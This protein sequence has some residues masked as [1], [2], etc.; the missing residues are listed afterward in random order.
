[1]RLFRILLLPLFIIVFASL[2]LLSRAPPIA[3]DTSAEKSVFSADRALQH[4]T[5]IAKAPHPT[6][7]DAIKELKHYLLNELEGLGLRTEIQ[8]T[9]V[10]N[11]TAYG[12]RIASIENIIAVKRGL[13]PDAKK[14]ALMAHYDSREN[15]FGASDDGSGIITILETLRA[16]NYLPELEND[17]VVLFTDGEETGLFGA[18]AFTQHPL[19]KQIGLILNFEAR[20]SS[21]PVVMFETSDNNA[22]LISEFVKAAPYPQ[23]DSLAYAIYKKMPNSTDL[24]ETKNAGIPGLNFAFSGSFFDYHSM[25]DRAENISADSVQHAGSYALALTQHFGHLSLPISEENKAYED[26]VYF[27]ITAHQLISYPLS[28][29]YLFAVFPLVL[30]LW[31]IKQF[32]RTESIS[33]WRLSWTA[34]SLLA[35]MAWVFVLVQ[36]L[37]SL[38]DGGIG[39]KHPSYFVLLYTQDRLFTGFSLLA[40][41]AFSAGVYLLNQ[42]PSN[43]LVASLQLLTIILMAISDNLQ[44]TIIGIFLASSLIILVQVKQARSSL[45]LHQAGFLLWGFMLIACLVLLPEAAHL[46]TWPLLLALT[47]NLVLPSY[48]PHIQTQTKILIASMLGATLAIYW[49]VSLI[50]MIYAA[51][52]LSVPGI[53]V[54]ALGLLLFLVIP[55]LIKHIQYSNGLV[56][57]GVFVAGLI[58]ILSTPLSFEFDQRYKRPDSLLYLQD[59]SQKVSESYWVSTDIEVPKWSEALFESVESSHRYAEDIRYYIPLASNGWWQAS[60]DNII[61]EPPT[62]TILLDENPNLNS[63]DKTHRKVKFKLNSLQANE[64]ISLYFSSKERIISATLN[65]KEIE[66]SPSHIAEKSWWHWRYYG[67]PKNGVDISLTIEGKEELELKVLAVDWGFS[68]ELLDSMPAR[69]EDTMPRFYSYSDAIVLFNQFKL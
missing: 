57:V 40:I 39:L 67:L 27:N 59:S 21:G 9:E 19:A 26:A 47:V 28:W 46:F 32:S 25:G 43:K 10:I 65:G 34:L 7:S 3:M 62:I 36:C 20:G 63:E 52:G 16:L 11:N 66:R 42:K 37:Y 35:L 1:M 64:N 14:L 8:Q 13:N 12:P 50:E 2:S 69:P 58:I 44:F 18:K 51:V 5:H 60:T 31:Q 53:P 29:A 6:G 54:S 24:T 55:A 30:L 48:F 68:K 56:V 22:A 4:L 23:A 49:M 17:L 41:A 38:I 33:L 15:S 61:T 45:A